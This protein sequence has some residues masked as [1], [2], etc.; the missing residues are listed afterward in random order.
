MQYIQFQPQIATGVTTP[1]S[2]SLNLFLDI[3]DNNIKVKNS[4][5]N[6][7]E[8]S[9]ITGG[10]FS[11][12]TITF[13]DNQGPSFSVTGITSN[14]SLVL[15]TYSE[16]VDMITGETLNIGTYYEIT[17]FKTCY[18]QPDYD[19]N[20]NAIINGIYRDDTEI[21]PIIVFATNINTISDNVFQ[22]AYPKDKIKY[23][24]TFNTTERTGGIA[25]GRITER[26]D[27][28]NN[29]TDYDHRTILFKRYRYYELDLSS[30]YQGTVE[31]TSTSSTE[32][33]VYGNNTNFESIGVGTKLGFNNN[34]YRVYEVTNVSSNDVM[35]I[36][37][38]TTTNLNQNTKMYSA[39]WDEYSSYY[40]N[41]V[42][43]SSLFE[44][45]YTFN[46]NNDY[47]NYIGNHANLYQY[48]ENDFIL[49]NNVFHD[50]FIGNK[51]GDECYNNTFFDD[52]SN[53]N[54]GNYFYGN[55][56]DDDFD[57]NL[58]GNGFYEN[59]ITANFQRNKI[60]EDFRNNYI[61]QN[62]FYRNNIGNDFRDNEISGGDF[63][64]NKIG[65][66][67]NNNKL[68]DGAYKNNIGNGFN[69]NRIFS[70]FYGN[71]IGNGFNNNHIYFSFYDNII[72]EYYE[73]NNIGDV[74]YNV[75]DFYENRIGNRFNDN[76]IN[77]SFGLNSIGNSFVDNTIYFEFAN[78]VIENNFE[79]NTLGT[80]V[81]ETY[82]IY[83]HIASDMKGNLLLGNFQQN[84]I[85][86]GFLSNQI[87]EDFDYNKIG[88]YFIVNDIQN[89][90]ESNNV[91]NFYSSN[92]IQNNFT[93]NFI[94]NSFSQ[95]DIGNNFENNRI[96]NDFID[97]SIGDYFG[98][99]NNQ[100]RGN[101]IGNYFYNNTIGEYF[102]D[103]NIGDNFINNTID[104]YFQFNRIE[105][106]I[107]GI[108]FTDYYGNII[109]F[110][111][112]N[113]GTTSVDGLYIGL[114]GVTNDSGGVDGTFDVQV[115][116]G[117]VVGVTGNSIGKL[118]RFNDTIRISGS[119]INGTNNVD[120]IIITVTS[121]R[122]PSVYEGY[123]CNIFMNSGNYYR[124]SYYDENDI[125]TIKNINE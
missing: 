121:V 40:Q 10:T 92:I 91:G 80:E 71:L 61:V 2:G 77:K 27:E 94:L 83:N 103:N 34:D 84:K 28:F 118:Y 44:E 7:N 99:G 60:G 6:I 42:D 3:S 67:F 78:N 69:D 20:K 55:I 22:P 68:Y 111:Y 57:G 90:F 117:S 21:S 65:N 89:N 95:N 39:D 19:Y 101:V 106:Q 107:N 30:P 24:W 63:Q 125:L 86:Y 41:N 115:N 1:P 31:V 33:I 124:L 87:G 35:T 110:T 109:E 18:D 64:N 93:Y 52:C 119:E 76:S 104:E 37:G 62:S 105:T 98:I 96:A 15:T 82:F 120:D 25:Y 114:S 112:T 45:Y 66:Q 75:G 70:N 122:T 46:G 72:G 108:D 12:N 17:D 123:N 100:S 79:I 58:I 48:N 116:G 36:T 14:Q 81:G 5:G 51:F 9:Y 38:L 88:D 102:Y 85:G 47:N 113:T 4:D 73:E 26:I 56:T 13:F 8:S 43:N 54:I 11:N 16:L 29:R 23:D 59:K 97:N 50:K 49:A 32:M 74:L 53:N